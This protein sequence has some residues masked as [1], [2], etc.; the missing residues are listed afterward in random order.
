[1]WIAINKKPKYSYPQILKKSAKK[2]KNKTFKKNQN[3]NMKNKKLPSFKGEQLINIFRS[4]MN[5]RFFICATMVMAQ[6]I[7]SMFG[8]GMVSVNELFSIPATHAAEGI[9]HTI[10]YQGKLMDSSGG[11][12]SDGNYGMKFSIYDSASGGSQLWT[13]SSTLG[14]P[15]GTPENVSV[16]VEN[17]LF[18]LLL[19]DTSADQV[20]FPD[21][22]FNKDE[23]YLGVTIGSDSEMTPRKR[24]SAV[25]YAYNSEMLQGQHASGTVDGSLGGDLF[26]LNQNSDTPA[27]ATRTALG[28]YTSGTSDTYDYLIRGNSGSDVFTV[29]RAGNVSTTGNLQ[30]DGAT[31]VGSATTTAVTFNGYV[32]SDFNPYSD[33]TYNLGSS[34]YRWL[35]LN[36][37]NVTS[38]N[39]TTTNLA[40]GYV[41]TSELWV[42]GTQITGAGSTSNLQQVTDQGATTTNR[43][44]FAGATSTNN[45][46][47]GT[48]LAYDLGS[49]S[50]RWRD[51]WASST[52]IGTSTWDLWQAN[53]G[54]TISE[55]LANRY[56]TISHSGNVGIG[57][58]SPGIF[59]LQIAGNTGP[60]TDLTYSLGSSSYRWLGLAAANVSSTNI[61]ALGYVSTTNLFAD[62]SNLGNATTTNL[63]NS[64]TVSTTELYVNGTQI[65]GASPEPSPW[66]ENASLNTVSLATSSRFVGIGTSTASEALDVA[67]S[68]RN[69]LHDDNSI[70]EIASTTVKSPSSIAVSGK[71]AYVSSLQN[72]LVII[73]ISEPSHPAIIAT[74]SIDGN[75]PYQVAVGGGYAYTANEGDETVS[76]VDV[77][78]PKTP[79]FVT[80]T[81]LEINPYTLAISGP[82][83][84]V[85]G[86]GENTLAVFNVANPTNPTLIA[87]TTVGE[88]PAIATVTERFISLAG[89]YAYVTDP[90]ANLLSVVDIINPSLPTEIATTTIANSPSSVAVSGRYAYTA[91]GSFGGSMSVVDISDPF[92]PVEVASTTVGATSPRSITVSG[93][94]AYVGASTNISVIDVYDPMNPM[95]VDVVPTS[96]YPFFITISGKYIYAVDSFSWQMSV[97]EIEGTESASLLAHS[98]EIG[99]LEVLNSANINNQFTIGGGLVVGSGGIFSNNGLGVHGTST[100]ADLTLS[101]RVNSNLLPYLTDTYSLGNTSYRWLGISAANVTTTN[102][103]ADYV[104][105]SEL[106]VGGTQITG[107]GSTSNLQQVTDV[108]ATTTNR[109]QFAGATSTN[110]ILPGTDNLFSLGSSSYRWSNLFAINASLVNVSSTNIDA[111]GDV[112]TTNLS[113]SASTTFNG[114]EY[115]FPNADGLNNQALVTN[116]TGGLSWQTIMGSGGSNIW[117]ENLANNTAHL[118]T[119]TRYVLLGGNTTSTAGFIWQPN[120]NGS[121]DLFIGHSTKTNAYYGTSTYGG[122]LHSSFSLD[123][124]DVFVQ[125]KLGAI[126]GLYSATS[127]IVGA[128]STIYGDGTLTKEL[129]GK[130]SFDILP[131]TG[132]T[133]IESFESATFPPT[134]WS[135]DGDYLWSRNSTQSS[136]GTWSAYS[137]GLVKSTE[138]YLRTTSTYSLAGT[139]SFDWWLNTGTG[140]YLNFCI[141][142]NNCTSGA[143]ASR[144]GGS[145]TWLSVEIPVSPGE[146]TF[147][148]RLNN[149]TGASNAA[150][151]DNVAFTSGGSIEGYEF[152][153]SSTH[154]MAIYEN[155]NIGMG[156]GATVPT[157]KLTVVGNIQNTLE[158]GQEFSVATSTDLV[159]GAIADLYVAGDYLY[160]T[161]AEAAGTMQ[162]FNIADKNNIFRIS[163]TTLPHGSN[164]NRILVDANYLYT[165]NPNSRYVQIIDISDP[166]SPFMVTSTYLGSIT[167]S[168]NDIAVNGNYLYVLT[169]EGLKVLNIGDINNPY[170]T[171]STNQGGRNFIKQGRFLYSED[172]NSSGNDYFYIID[173][174]NPESP[175][176]VGTISL[177]VSYDPSD[178]YVKGGYAYITAVGGYTAPRLLVVDISDVTNPNIIKT[179]SLSAVAERLHGSGRYLYLTNHQVFDIDD[180][181]NPVKIL[182]NSIS[183]NNVFSAGRY[184]YF[185]N[186]PWPGG[187]LVIM[188]NGGIETNGI[189]AHN[190]QLGSVQILGDARVMN[191]LNVNN[192]MSVGSGGIYTGGGLVTVATSSLSDINIL[193]RVN[194]NLLPYLTDTYTLGNSNYRWLGLNVANVTTTNLAASY[195]TTSELWV[196]GTQITGAESQSLQDVTD[197]GATTTNRI[198]FAGATSTNNILPGTDNLFSLGSSSYRWANLFA[199]NSSLVNVSST[200]IDALGYVSTTNLYASESILGNATTTN[201]YNS[202]TVSTTN[203]YVNGT[204]IT[205]VTPTLQQVTDQGYITSNPIGFAGASSTGHFLPT[206]NNSYDLGSPS[207]GWRN[208]YASNGIFTNVSSTN[209]DALSYVSTTNLYVNGTQI[210]GAESQSL[211]DVTDIGATT[212]NRIQF[213]GATSTNNILPGTNL[214]Y[215]LGSSAYRWDELWVS[216]THIGGSTWDLRQDGNGYFTIAEN[217]GASRLTMDTNGRFGFGTTTPDALMHIYG[218]SDAP[219]VVV[220]ANSTQDLSNPLIQF[221]NSNGTV[222]GGITTNATTNIFAGLSA[223]ESVSS[224]DNNSF[225]GSESGMFVT[226][227][228]E[229]TAVGSQALN[230]NWDNI[231]GSYNTAIGSESMYGLSGNSI[232]G[233]Y[234]SALGY[235]SLL[236]I[237]T[238]HDN[239]AIGSYTLRSLTS[240]YENTAL[241]STALE[242]TTT[243]IKNIGIGFQAAWSNSTGT[244]NI[245]IG[246]EALYNNNGDDNV[247]IGKNASYIATGTSETIA[248]GYEALFTNNVDGNVGIGFN[249]VRANSSG[250]R[251]SGVGRSVMINN[252][253]GSDNTAIGY[254]SSYFNETGSYNTSLGSNA[255]YGAWSNSHS[256]NTGIGYNSLF[257]VTTGS[258]NTGLG[259]GSLATLTTGASNT[260]IGYN[261]GSNLTSGANNI[262]IGSNTNAP[263]ATGNNQLNIGNALYGNLDNSY[264]GIGDSSPA[265]LFTVGSG[266]TFQVDSSGDLARINN[267]PYAWPAGNSAGSLTN[268]GSGNLSW[269]SSSGLTSSTAFI[270]N[271]NSF[272]ASAVLGTNDAHDLQFETDGVS[273]AAI[274]NAGWFGIGTNNPTN[275][276]TIVSSTQLN[277]Q[278]QFLAKFE[279][280]SNSGVDRG[281]S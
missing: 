36:V 182:D 207:F 189:E 170:I 94:Y 11:I 137:G 165:A 221:R 251:L 169:Y 186:N 131:T 35:G 65:T 141:D 2:G 119:S 172:N 124:N 250:A 279:D 118:T 167:A 8:F 194:S 75:L 127:V 30:V 254:E 86:A 180:P 122:G 257:S 109:I 82:H 71:Y 54:F 111:L 90:D 125:G 1:M 91:N 161:V 185:G 190:A 204:Q 123:G 259:S 244:A 276:F 173:T 211:Q 116:G 222:I 34:A 255:M 272:G 101:G 62:E 22:L 31:I 144:N 58:N 51:V 33:L 44:Q 175:Q 120:N 142:D 132:S 256:H 243:G 128:N 96:I 77:T 184:T 249:A 20:A 28:I 202:G 225:F 85:V 215:D 37:A 269:S 268:D 81:S 57:T 176:T 219:Q 160:L 10:N 146:H 174:Q 152:N 112:S 258:N 13:A 153:V 103:A 232:T 21:D 32:S 266:D 5:A 218:S 227:G 74:S 220:Q 4:A 273:R 193:G 24:L 130:Y 212:T 14:I 68:I 178:I 43:I 245:A 236:N 106:W 263:S 59:K 150:Y 208:I 42:D 84:Y 67:G 98:A 278:D 229:N 261:A 12:V 159:S 196:D 216:S 27:S 187:D 205:G 126:G 168:A 19:G 15:T 199:I 233:N 270:Q 102:L 45:I 46:L 113:V 198:Q 6:V 133:S 135:T 164:H 38:T 235:Q 114:V 63:Y 163:T 50:N 117:S 97:N 200:N 234:N 108:G 107:A 201:L 136:D 78:N 53:E 61:D 210:T 281:F 76:V 267:V 89:R 177:N 179:V 104:T 139:V 9:A 147:T 226:T 191:Q 129:G 134:G 16:A 92:N 39:V 148:W 183:S 239:T 231:S 73:D 253:S 26:A 47:P 228:D 87:T 237:N 121:S 195:V 240:G 252:T 248:V 277:G 197:I 264:I 72:E 41:T 105:T 23:L 275:P 64:G 181:T 238:G 48:N 29:T 66:I 209:I 158:A 242:G 157:N 17:G 188:D 93:R 49:S 156:T 247:A 206:A 246:N 155:R 213:A 140:N 143:D 192:G 260:A 138:S 271:G 70:T 214:A 265:S 7:G 25:P 55:G 40:A 145:G 149:S 171:T 79:S 203:L 223:G 224:G 83:L 52:R 95:V 217:G 60:D 110:N 241:G 88:Q 154:A 115:L 230:G 262:I 56:F 166:G 3:K 280:G 99:N 18:S 162:I 274:T 100:L 69:I 80:S 151:V